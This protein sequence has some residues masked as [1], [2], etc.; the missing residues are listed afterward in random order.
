[1]MNKDPISDVEFRRRLLIGL[2]AADCITRASLCR[3]AGQMDLWWGSKASSHPA[4]ALRLGV[5]TEQLSKVQD[6]LP[7]AESLAEAE[8]RRAEAEGCWIV[9]RDEVTYPRVLLDHPLPPPV[10]Y[11]RGEIPLDTAVAMVGSRKMNAYGQRVAEH[12]ARRLAASGVT[13]VSGFARGVDTVAHRSALEAGGRTVAVLGCGI[14]VDYP[15]SSRK[16]ATAIEGH[17]ALVTEF[18][19]GVE[20]RPW[21]FPIRNRVIAALSAG[22]LVVQA[23]PRSGSLITAHLALDLGREVWA[24]PGSVF[25]P[26]CRGTNDLI[27]DGAAIVR[28]PDDI[29]LSLSMTRSLGLLPEALE[30]E[31]VRK[32][33]QG[34]AGRLLGVLGAEEALPAEELADRLAE[35]VDRILAILLELELE[36]WVEREPGPLYRRR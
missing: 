23:A 18:A 8:I 28:E 12:F 30:E 6:L 31:V 9:T 36:G 20:P 27:A 35:P 25:E 16:L 11:G 21:H 24:V 29:L 14:D 15:R 22:T 1:M 4:L 19:F 32:R 5:P 10:L 17:G 26:L 34:M 33:P 2:N 3:L 13:V 7:R